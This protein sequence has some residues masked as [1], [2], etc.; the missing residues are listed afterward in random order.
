MKSAPVQLLLLDGYE[1][2]SA[3]EPR[4]SHPAVDLI[5]EG[6]PAV[7]VTYGT[8][9]PFEKKG[10][11]LYSILAGLVRSDS[12]LTAL[13][14]ARVVLRE[15]QPA[16]MLWGLPA[17]YLSQPDAVLFAPP[18]KVESQEP[19]LLQFEDPTT[20]TLYTVLNSL[21]GH[22]FQAIMVSPA[23]QAR[24]E[25]EI[26]LSEQSALDFFWRTI[27]GP[28][29]KMSRNYSAR[30]HETEKLLSDALFRGEALD[31]FRRSVAL[32]QA[33][34]LAFRLRLQIEAGELENLPWEFITRPENQQPLALQDHISLVRF[35]PPALTAPPP[36]YTS[37]QPLRALAL[38]ANPAD[39]P[40]FDLFR[41]WSDLQGAFPE[42]IIDRV[43]GGSLAD[44]RKALR[45]QEYAITVIAG[46]V[47][48]REDS[49]LPALI[50]EDREQ[51][52]AAVDP[53][54]LAAVLGDHKRLR[55]VILLN[56]D[57][58]PAPA[59]P[60]LTFAA[61][62]A[63]AGMPA[64]ITSPVAMTQNEHQAMLRELYACL[65]NGLPVDIALA[66]ARMAM[67]AQKADFSWGLPVLIS[68]LADG[69]LFTLSPTQPPS[70]TNLY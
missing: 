17:L 46:H 35:L 26:P 44:L 59:N 10:E 30:A 12:I 11:L 47:V 54:T 15:N 37:D 16:S 28:T 41:E 2:R 53:S 43:E 69:I 18:S 61:E 55:L 20:I 60:F 6:A 29:P 25:A 65:A 49:P 42:G 8:A 19:S 5:R 62:L 64:V 39:M 31:L 13:A 24:F 7:L 48:S 51:R 68:R 21:E 32:A 4:R 9:M 66:E 36:V 3:D 14:N 56:L 40:P 50:L 22:R 38:I 70:D 63:K 58:T 57:G 1:R 67:Y 33:K 45:Q 34:N 52:S 27:P 23:G